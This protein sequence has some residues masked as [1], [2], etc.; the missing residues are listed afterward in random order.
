[1]KGWVAR[2]W[3][4]E[5]VGRWMDRWVNGRMDGWV[6]RRVSGQ[7]VGGWVIGRRAVGR[8]R[9]W[10]SSNIVSRSALC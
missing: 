4:G 7:Q 5:T 1:M 8:E 3:R 10:V 2:E 9:R 6:G